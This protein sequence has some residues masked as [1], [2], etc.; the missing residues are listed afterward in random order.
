MKHSFYDIE[1]ESAHPEIMAYLA[2]HNLEGYV[3]PARDEYAGLG[4]N[5][6]RKAFGL[7][8][9]DVW[10]FPTGT[11]TNITALAAILKPFEGVISPP[12]G[13]VH[14]SETGGLEATG[15]KIIQVDAVNGK[16]TP[17]AI[18]SA[19]N[20]PQGF[21]HIVPRAVYLTHVTE[22]GTVYTK[23]ELVEVISFAK[24]N[25]LHILLDGA[26]LGMAL[27]SQ[28]AGTTLQEFGALDLDMFYIGGT[29]NGGLFGEA[30]VIKSKALK[31]DFE[32][33]IQRQGANLSKRRVMDLQFARFFDQDDLWLTLGRHANEMAERLRE[34][35]IAAGMEITPE[36]D[37]N[38]AFV[39]MSNPAIETL[40]KDFGFSRWEK[41][42]ETTTKIRLVCSWATQAEDVDAFVD[43]AKTLAR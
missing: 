10:Y 31:P 37:A 30:L 19:L 34:G 7:P 25:D 3:D 2:E 11:A 28:T 9:A 36:S 22:E 21:R 38:H 26:R 27:A 32:R 24:Q 14:A 42:N 35:L 15:H 39:V 33:Y 1:P 16:L 18:Q 40:Q 4:V 20:G 6:I 41:I 12:T 43:A 29:K 23:D 13:H 17:S 8:D 5:R